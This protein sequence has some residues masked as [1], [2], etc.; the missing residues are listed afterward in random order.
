[1]LQS[2]GI[3]RRVYSGFF[4]GLVLIALLGAVSYRAASSLSTIFKD[5]QNRVR[6]SVLVSDL[7][8]DAFQVVQGTLAFRQSGNVADADMARQNIAEILE[9]RPE[10]EEVFPVGHPSRD[11]LLG[12]VAL[13]ATYA[14]RLEEGVAARL[15]FDSLVKEVR[16]TG[17]AAREEVSRMRVRAQAMGDTVT[18]AAVGPILEELMIGRLNFERFVSNSEAAFY[19]EAEA[20]LEKT[21]VDLKAF[22]RFGMDKEIV[23]AARTGQQAT[24]AYLEMIG[25]ARV[26]VDQRFAVAKIIFQDLAPAIEEGFDGAYQTLADSQTALGDEGRL[27][28]AQ[29]EQRVVMLAGLALLLATGAAFVVGRWIARSVMA[30]AART[31]DL[32]QGDLDSPIEGTAHAHELGAMARALEVFRDNA[33][34]VRQLDADKA[35][36]EERLRAARAAMM[37]ELQA[38]FGRAV[39]AA[40]AGDFSRRIDA[41]FPDRELND[42][43]TGVNTLLG[44]VES[45]LVETGRV[46]SRLAEGDLTEGMR[47]T[48]AGAFAELQRNMNDAV[49]RLADL[50]A[51]ISSASHEVGSRTGEITSVATNLARRA[52]AQAASLEQTAAA[53]EEMSA[54]IRANA[55]NARRASDKTKDAQGK[56]MRGQDVAASAVRAMGEIEQSSTKISDIIAVIDSIAFQT[57][58]L[59]LNA[60]VEAARAG[61]A[62]KGFAVVASEVRTLAQRSSEAARDIKAL[63]S[64]SST[65]VVDGVALVHASGEALRELYG[66]VEEVSQMV[67]DISSAST[68]QAST[69][70]EISSS[71]SEMDRITQANTGLADQSASAAQVLGSQAD[72]LA[73]LVRTFRVGPVADPTRRAA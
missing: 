36:E 9:L 11:A 68:E 45:G 31:E 8:E 22:D 63:I 51:S 34:R 67:S 30:M 61:D 52:E 23:A 21:M 32:A 37:Q 27:V 43:A 28:T 58:L 7:R 15:A 6:Q 57:N 62:G 49:R 70:T 12:T 53:I 47:G 50:I 64:Q 2:W 13:V 39:D 4:I 66:A 59:A 38:S 73:D 18:L 5:Y 41:N 46:V 33:R 60:A 55:D 44:T 24:A 16:A 14:A 71:V 48:F 65:K 10:L 54:T 56:A 26:L 1:M 3:A 29:T 72:R 69:M 42:L 17:L 19:A 25:R 40:V 20:N 35:A